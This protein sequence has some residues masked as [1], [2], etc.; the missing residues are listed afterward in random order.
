MRESAPKILLKAL[1]RPG[2]TSSLR[3]RLSARPPGHGK[4]EPNAAFDQPTLGLL[5]AVSDVQV[6]AGHVSA[7]LDHPALK[8]SGIS[9]W[10]DDLDTVLDMIRRGITE[11]GIGFRE[12]ITIDDEG[13]ADLHEVLAQCPS[14]EE[15]DWPDTAENRLLVR[16]TD[17]WLEQIGERGQAL[18]HLLIGA[19]DALEAARSLAALD[20]IRYP[21]V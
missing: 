16:L 10:L 4:A 18:L 14:A 9:R 7:L 20:I 2:K 11:G 1:P 15:V 8:N 6:L 17:W 5:L 13:P 12:G 19:D 21:F 3:Q